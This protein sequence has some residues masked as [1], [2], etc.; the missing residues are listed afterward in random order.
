VS[1]PRR[2]VAAIAIGLILLAGYCVARFEVTTD[3]T[4]FLDAPGRAS[5]GAL[6]RRL[7]RSDVTR[8]MVLSIAAPEL[9]TALETAG[10]LAS[11][12]EGDGN[13]AWISAG[14]DPDLPD[15]L[16]QLYFDHRYQLLSD[17][18]E[19]DLPGRLDDAGLTRAAADL[20]RAVGGPLAPL[21]KSTAPADP[22]MAFPELLRRLQGAG[23]PALEVR[24]G[25]FLSRNGDAAIVFLGTAAPALAAAR[26]APLLA[27]IESEFAALDP[28]GGADLSLELSSVHRF[29]V[30]AEQSMR[31][32]ISRI[33]TLSTAGILLLFLLVFRSIRL[34]AV[35]SLPLAAGLLTGLATCLLLYGRI[36]GLTLA[37]GGA[38]VGVCIDYPIHLLAHWLVD[39]ESPDASAALRVVW[40]GIRLGAATSFVGFAA[41]AGAGFPGIR[42]IGI[43]AGAGIAGAVAVTAGAVPFLVSRRGR[44]TGL[45][46]PARWTRTLSHA[47]AWLGR[48]RGAAAILPGLALLVCAAGLPGMRWTD[49]VAALSP[50]DPELVAEETRVRERVLGA[51]TSR[52]VIATGHSEEEALRRNDLVARTLEARVQDGTLREFRSLH[53]F[54]WSAELQNRNA[55]LVASSSRLDERMLDALE[56]EGFRPEAF[57]PFVES[58][59]RAPDPLRIADLEDSAIGP[60]VGPFVL[61]PDERNAAPETA[62]AL[63][64]LVRGVED[65]EAL[66]AAFEP[67]EGVFYLD[68]LERLEAGYR[69]LRRAALRYV[70]LGVLA[71]LALL[72]LHYRSLA[73]TGVALLP[74][75]LAVGTTAAAISLSGQPLN[76]VNLFGLLLVLGMGVDYG[77]FLAE[78]RRQHEPVGATALGLVL[79]CATS[80]L[81]LGLLSL[82][83]NP[84]LRSLGITT[85]VG[86]VSS[87][88]LGPAVLALL[89]RDDS[90]V[91]EAP[92]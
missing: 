81:G 72:W 91:A 14:P 35:A 32:D 28:T 62:F 79:S 71:V 58:L 11:R 45:I 66:A 30:R 37:F 26:N 34:I 4:D 24:D 73:S 78:S 6:S 54:V 21:V 84:G 17:D 55:E 2:R 52:V 76:L 67:M 85:A 12:L 8:T 31:R 70:A 18:P 19:A 10:E 49:D 92:R 82:S 13:V 20:K 83:S 61:P 63:V 27:R 64:S 23:T 3:I 38:L 33:S 7:T 51:E 16:H 43:F 77:V 60:W 90:T 22:L 53:S 47:I 88:L 87:L 74:A 39:E 25:R 59:S 48:H 86:V 40:P 46:G 29:A 9:D 1:R 57:L 69:E 65:P 56:R 36:N 89:G 50:V 5:E 68:Q 15:L 80:V 41:L 75:L 42:E 44:A